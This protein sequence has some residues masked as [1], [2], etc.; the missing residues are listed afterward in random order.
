MSKARELLDMLNEGELSQFMKAQGK[1]QLSLIKNPAGTYH[2]VGSVPVKLGWMNKDGSEL[3]D[4]EA[5]ELVKSSSPGMLGK[6]RV[7][8]TSKEALAFAKKMGIKA[9]DID[10]LD[11]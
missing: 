1:F 11:K 4:K 7:F 3:S 2:F 8:K 9:K 5:K 10:V 6:S